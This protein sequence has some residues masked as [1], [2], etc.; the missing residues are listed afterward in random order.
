MSPLRAFHTRVKLSWGFTV[1]HREVSAAQPA[2]VLPPPT[3]VVGAFAYPLLRILGI[4]PYSDRDERYEDH[5]LISPIMKHLLESTKVA[6]AAISGRGHGVIGLVVHQE[7]GRLATAPYRGG[8]SWEKAK[9]APLFSDVFYSN[10]IPQA[11]AVQALGASYG[12]GA[13]LELLWVVDAGRLAK[14]LGISLEQFD[15][16]G[17]KAV[18]GVVRLGSKEGLVSVEHE[19]SIYEVKVEEVRAGERI[20]S[21]M[22]AE[23][24]CVDPIDHHL[25]HEITL[26][27]ISGKLSQYYVPAFTGSNILVVPSTEVEPPRFVILQPCRGYKLTNGVVGVGR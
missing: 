4:N 5:R 19:H 23:K 22:Y 21:W 16:A 2:F 13:L 10:T 25:V 20:R 6:S 1:R 9:K 17:R 26:M 18:H 12:P 3:T 7:L 11:F 14:A 27:D 8:G 24:T 15:E